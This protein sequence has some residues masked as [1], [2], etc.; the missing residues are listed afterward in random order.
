MPASA[1]EKSTLPVSNG[2]SI[3]LHFRV[4]DETNELTVFVVDQESKRVL[5]SIPASELQKMKA[6]DLLKLTA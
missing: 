6:G 4:N 1:D 5:R 2:S 3:T